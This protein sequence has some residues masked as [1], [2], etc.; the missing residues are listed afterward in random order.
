MQSLLAIF[1]DVGL[2]AA[3]FALAKTAR[4]LSKAATARNVVQDARMDVQDSRI[5]KLVRVSEA[6]EARLER[7][8]KAA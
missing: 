3:A 1:V 6:H 8:E 7:V 4:D 5:D 2:G